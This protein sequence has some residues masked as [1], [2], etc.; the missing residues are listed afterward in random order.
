MK[1][2]NILFWLAILL[3]LFAIIVVVN[4]VA[5]ISHPSI[6][7]LLYLAVSVVITIV[8]YNQVGGFKNAFR[9]IK[10]MF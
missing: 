9:Q 8:T 4:L 5:L 3:F 1:S 6:T 7:G 10:K 2:K